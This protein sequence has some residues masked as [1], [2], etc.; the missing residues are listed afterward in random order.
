MAQGEYSLKELGDKVDPKERADIESAVADLK[1]VIKTGDKHVIET[2]TQRLSDVSAKMAERLY[3][4]QGAQQQQAQQQ[5]EGATQGAAKDD[6][7]L[8]AEFEEVK[9]DKKE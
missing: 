1:E 7:V 8:D 6:D 3:G 4:Q 2:K 9:D 5:A